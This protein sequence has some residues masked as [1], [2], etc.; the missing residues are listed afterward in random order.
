[1]DWNEAGVAFGTPPP[2]EARNILK[3]Q[4]FLLPNALSAGHPKANVS[5]YQFQTWQ[6]VATTKGIEMRGWFFLFLLAFNLYGVWVFIKSPVKSAAAWKVALFVL[7]IPVLLV[8]IYEGSKAMSPVFSVPLIL[9][10]IP[11]L[12]SGKHL[13]DVSRDSTKARAGEF[14]GFPLAAW[15]VL[16][17]LGAGLGLLA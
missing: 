5:K 4:A 13:V 17:A 15:A 8:L 11:W 9:T 7:G 1:M 6:L 12:F 10:V 14:I 3:L 2:V 16:F